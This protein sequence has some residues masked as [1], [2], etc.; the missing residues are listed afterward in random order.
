MLSPRDR[1]FAELVRRE[2]LA[3]PEE[4]RRGLESSGAE[5]P[6]LVPR[7]LVAARVIDDT[8]RV[9]LEAECDR[10]KRCCPC[11]EVF[12]AAG[13]AKVPCPRCETR[14]GPGVAPTNLDLGSLA[15]STTDPNDVE[16]EPVPEER[17]R[18][19]PYV[20]VEELGRGG[21]GV[22][23]RARQEPLGRLVAL[24]V[25]VEPK[26]R[27]L[28]RFVRE[29][30]AA[31]K[32]DH[33]NVVRIHDVGVEEGFIYY[34]MELLEGKPLDRILF[35]EGKLPWR[36]ALA[37]LEPIC[38]AVAHVHANN[39]LH[40]DLKPANILVTRGEKPVLIDF[41]LVR[42]LDDEDVKLTRSGAAIGTPQYMSPEQVRGIRAEIDERTDVWA[43]GVIIFEL[44]SGD[45]PYQGDTGAELYSAIQLDDA[46]RLRT[47]V[48]GCP[49]AVDAI[50]AK[51]LERDKERRYPSALALAEDMT[52]ALQGDAPE[53]NALRERLARIVR[54][55]RLGTL[56]ITL[57]GV[58]LVVV[59]GLAVR[60]LALKREREATLAREAADREHVRRI[61]LDV[62]ARAR[63]RTAAASL[64]DD[65]AAARAAAED[66]VAA[67]DSL[68]ETLVRAAVTDGGRAEARSQASAR[69]VEA[70]ARDALVARARAAL[71]AGGRDAFVVAERDAARARRGAA[72]EVELA[73]LHAAALV[74]LERADE[75]L[76]ALGPA[77]AA[78]P[79]D[80][81]LLLREGEAKIAA[82]EAKE[83]V[84][85]VE[86][87]AAAHPEDVALRVAR[88][89]AS[90]DAGDPET[91]LQLVAAL[92]EKAEAGTL[93][94]E[95]ALAAGQT[96][97]A[98]NLAREIAKKRGPEDASGLKARALVA[99]AR[100][101][102]ELQERLLGKLLA[103]SPLDPELLAWRARA[104]IL[105]LDAGA[106]NDLRAAA[107]NAAS[108]RR[109]VRIELELAALDDALGKS[110]EA[111]RAVER[112]REAAGS[113][114][115]ARG[116]V[117]VALAQRALAADPEDLR[118]AEDAVAAAL[119]EAPRAPGLDATRAWL[120]VREGDAR[121]ALE[122][123]AAAPRDALAA[124][125]EA[126]ARRRLGDSGAAR[127]SS[128][129]SA[130]ED[131]APD[132]AG[133]LERRARSELAFALH[134][135]APVA[136]RHAQAALTRAMWAAALAPRRAGAAA[137]AGGALM[138]LGKDRTEARRHL[139]RAA[140][141]NPKHPLV[142]LWG[143]LEA[144]VGGKDGGAAAASIAAALDASPELA[145]EPYLWLRL[146]D[147]RVLARDA[148]GAEVASRRALELDPAS[149]RPL[150]LLV[151]AAKV[152]GDEA[153]IASA[154]AAL[155]ARREGRVRARRLL[156]QTAVEL[157]TDEE[158][159]I[160]R[161]AVRLAPDDG[162]VWIALSF[163]RFKT[164]D[165]LA[166]WRDWARALELEPWDEGHDL[167]ERM[168]QSTKDLQGVV[169]GGE[170]AAAVAAVQASEPRAAE[171]AF[172]HA[173]TEWARVELTGEPEGDHFERAIGDLDAA[174][175][176]DP[177]FLVA[178]ALR[179]HIRALRGE[180]GT[181]RA[182]LDR[183]LDAAPGRA[184]I[185][186]L[187]RSALEASLGESDAAYR[188]LVLAVKDGFRDRTRVQRLPALWGLREEPR[189][190]QIVDRLGE[191]P[192]TGFTE[193]F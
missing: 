182:D 163:A 13:E 185:V 16:L 95:A 176:E 169:N 3:S 102:E 10:W 115:G 134:A 191:S 181:A 100:G 8:M 129:A 124:S 189:F 125:V 113:D 34:S 67:I 188:E 91:A 94:V 151:R 150:E 48:P 173:W 110:D 80:P 155:D 146:G 57:V 114:S 1:F 37:V 53:A 130:L 143:G 157:P 82:G 183:A 160:L 193:G 161:E 44:I 21:M 74:A 41:G 71:A 54:R 144:L 70:A 178:L 25:L 15:P 11:G 72:D 156:R 126:E 87:A 187:Y 140:L 81:R 56:A 120:A 137:I 165:Y 174:I 51:A 39:L 43:L 136:T 128:E 14:I 148:P 171:L 12:Y 149:A 97:R 65:P 9:R 108:P 77:L 30:R 139:D 158:L 31:A 153:A 167:E 75:A 49:P 2:G 92:G 118:S 88:A 46:P 79:D 35:E 131:A 45:R 112:A 58:A 175:A 28:E 89:R 127:A 55:A 162:R 105:G 121:R 133:E 62:I 6:G 64:A 168:Y 177:T 83:G 27:R 106:A 180:V 47:V 29:A 154:T 84:A 172:L 40:R 50:V 66:S 99:R 52:R 103:R 69:E 42:A 73:G 32:L 96:S 7:Y 63:A 24:K 192:P 4:I 179:G 123:L 109:R 76:T 166:A 78:H 93:G 85:L 145:R 122:L 107:E 104:R 159:A 116:L 86:R 59:A 36:R 22:V 101:D 152:S 61:A 68:E 5:E 135:S 33:P 26:G 141:W 117:D 119:R 164:G 17:T 98:A 132:V 60:A 23:Y 170:F 111:A 19:G 20:V 186:H 38:R 190:R 138:G 142:L 18:Y 90:L 184:P 147:A